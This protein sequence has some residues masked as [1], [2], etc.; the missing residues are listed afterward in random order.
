MAIE[1]KTLPRKINRPAMP[2]LIKKVPEFFKTRR[3]AFIAEV[4]K[5][6]E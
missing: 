1:M 5:L 6:V 2:S 3:K 4:Q